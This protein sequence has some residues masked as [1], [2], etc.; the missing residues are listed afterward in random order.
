MLQRRGFITA[1]LCLGLGCAEA[2]GQIS[3]GSFSGPVTSDEL[4]SFRTYMATLV[5]ATSNIGNTWAQGSSGE[6]VK[7]MGLVYEVGHDSG[8]LDQMIRFCDAVL[9]E[10]N[11]LASAPV[12]QYVIWSGD[13]APVWPNATAAPINTGGEQGD[14][15]GHLGNCARLIL[16]SPELWWKIV[17]IGD[18][19]GYGKTYLE[20]ART[21]MQ[22]ADY[23]IDHHILKYELD[24]SNSNRQYFAAGD[25][26]KPGEAV[27]WNQQ[28]MF[29]YG[30]QNLAT[31]HEI[32]G[33]D[34]TRVT[35][36]R[37]IVQDSI[38]WFF[39]EGVQTIT[40]PAGL[41]A[42]QWG[43]QM[44]NITNE[45][46]NHG[47]LDV[48]GFQRAYMSGNFGI[49][50]DQMTKFANTIVDIVTQSPTFYTGYLNGKTGSGNSG[51][52]GY[53][54]AAYVFLAEFRPDAYTDMLAGAKIIENSQSTNFPNFAR[55]LWVKYRRSLT[56][57][58]QSQAKTT[59]LLSW[60]TAQT[61]TV[62]ALIL[63]QNQSSEVWQGPFS[64]VLS[65]ANGATLDNAF[66]QGSL[67]GPY[68]SVPIVRT[69]FPGQFALVPVKLRTP[70]N[71]LP[72]DLVWKVTSD[73]PQ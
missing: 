27:P 68:V 18:P 62:D 23:S 19:N 58:V 44:P 54:R 64:L 59:K 33:D 9:S 43:Y 36:Y 5:P 53:L 65:G 15:V 51:S 11:D 69:L 37:K 40:D 38:N 70:T 2:S 10:R 8:T 30:F 13:I 21:F 25:P 46:Q 12:G 63:I 41:P 14:P 24:L 22:G 31:A 67:M 28:M 26:Y 57:S 48:A 61:N 66:A 47:A 55:F 71:D 42:Y 34:P 45:D 39:T 7:A 50:A 60:Y 1:V 73:Q 29:N 6:A 16:S 72:K 56:G 4:V 3:V 17:P 32:L 49:T 35:R 52:T 20:R